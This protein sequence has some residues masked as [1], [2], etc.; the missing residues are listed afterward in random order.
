MFDVYPPWGCLVWTS[1]SDRILFNKIIKKIDGM[2]IVTEVMRYL[3]SDQS[4]LFRKTHNWESIL[5]SLDRAR[6]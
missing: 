5:S 1:E 3:P 4:G 2:P 6:S